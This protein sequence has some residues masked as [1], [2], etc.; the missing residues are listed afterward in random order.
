MLANLQLGKKFTIFMSAVFI[1]GLLASGFA[2][3]K[4]L[5][6]EAEQQV[7]SKGMILIEAMR[8][9]RWY[10]DDHLKPLLDSGVREDTGFVPET[11]PAF[12]A[13]VVFE[14]FRQYRGYG[15]FSYK[16]ASLN[17]TNPQNR[18]DS[19]EAELIEQLSRAQGPQEITGFRT[20]D[21][22][23]FFFVTR[24]LFLNEPSCLTC[25]SDPALAP[26][27]MIAR[28]GSENGFGLQLNQLAATQIVYVPAEEVY[29]VATRSFLLAMGV[30]G[31]VF[32]VAILLINLLLRR[33]VVQPVSV[34]GGLAQK[35]KNDEMEEQDL[36]SAGLVEVS[37]R[38]DELGALA[39]VFR[40]MARE[41]YL[42]TQTL[43]Q[44]VRVLRIGIDERK[45]EQDMAEIVESDFFK[46]LQAKARMIRRRHH[47][48]PMYTLLLPPASA[49]QEEPDPEQPVP[50]TPPARPEDD[51]RHTIQ[52]P[53]PLSDEQR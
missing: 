28:Y 12:S 20:L 9:V 44:E 19:F 49:Q 51:P 6:R 43:K 39:Q 53:K 27:E 15:D 2:L 17:P 46:E 18:A 13:R 23:P 10:T 14:R 33:Y 22:R 36:R 41:V 31:G 26:P 11:V 16:E 7:A 34:V 3:W 50:Q 52:L 21:S 8:S 35:I 42:R 24:P 45:R 38:A 25:H 48:D 47:E 29:A 32:I 4:I 5:E 1:G 37:R 30:S 40:D